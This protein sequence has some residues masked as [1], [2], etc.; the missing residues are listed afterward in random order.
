MPSTRRAALEAMLADEPDDVF[1][2]YSLALELE[3]EG[4]NAGSQRLLG[5]LM[6]ADKPYVPAFVMAGQFLVQHGTD[7]AARDV[8]RA[9]IAVARAQGDEHAA[10][11]MAEF[12]AGLE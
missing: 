9:G 6:A 8:F 3:K 5:E 7:E 10:G 4:D 12:L 11:E 1:L 2:R